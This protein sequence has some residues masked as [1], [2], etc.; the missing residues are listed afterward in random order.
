M[1]EKDEDNFGFWTQYK[2]FA[3][4]ELL[5]YAIMVIYTRHNTLLPTNKVN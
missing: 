3:K 1:K 5:L 2:Q 4:N